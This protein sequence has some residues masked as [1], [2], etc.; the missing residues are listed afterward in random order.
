MAPTF[1][2]ADFDSIGLT[3]SLG[4]PVAVD[5]ELTLPDGTSIDPQKVKALLDSI[6]QRIEA[7]E[8]AGRLFNAAGQ[9]MGW[10]ASLR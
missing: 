6:V 1:Q 8:S 7:G 10:F 5:F 3:D 2:S 4:V 9:D